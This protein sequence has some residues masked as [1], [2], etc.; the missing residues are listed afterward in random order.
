MQD[1]REKRIIETVIF[2]STLLVIAVG[3]IL[4]ILGTNWLTVLI[5]EILIISM[6]SMLLLLLSRYFKKQNERFTEAEMEI[7]AFLSGDLSARLASNE[8]GELARFFEKVNHMAIALQTH[9]EKEQN[10]RQ[11]LKETIFDISHQLKTPLAAIKM[12]NEII[13]NEKE[14]VQIVQKFAGKSEKSIERMEGLIQNLMKITKLDAGTIMLE[15]EDYNTLVT[16]AKK[17]VVQVK[18]ESKLEKALAAAEKT[19]T[20]LKQ[21]VSE[22]MNTVA[23]LTKQLDQYRSVRG[24]P[25]SGKLQSENMELRKQ[26]NIFKSIIEQH[27][28]GHLLGRTKDQRQTRDAR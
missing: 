8:E 19:I 26:N 17:Y 13:Q 15:K 18:R 10:S 20:G 21:K 28:L 12:Y 14:D 6:C 22:L 2:G 24:Q 27:G 16:A 9:V 3:I 4:L 11:F 23:S 25:E 5:I 7:E 1:K